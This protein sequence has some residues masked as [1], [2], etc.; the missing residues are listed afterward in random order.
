M[1]L[2]GFNSDLKRPILRYSSKYL[3]HGRK[4]WLKNQTLQSNLAQW[5]INELHTLMFFFLYFFYSFVPFLITVLLKIWCP[6][7]LLKNRIPT[8]S[9][10]DPSISKN[11]DKQRA[12]NL[13]I[14]QG[15]KSYKELPPS[16]SVHLW[17]WRLLNERLPN[18]C[19]SPL[20]H[21]CRRGNTSTANIWPGRSYWIWI[22]SAKHFRKLIHH[23]ELTLFLKETLK[24]QWH[25]PPLLLPFNFLTFRTYRYVIKQ[26]C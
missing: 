17:F 11:D 16:F 15:N 26:H 1:N 18:A 10:V 22:I 7:E 20:N 19:Q 3:Q 9:W 5:R 21:A 23:I 8:A 2:Q 14:K 6:S 12:T 24:V 13:I 4:F 25:H